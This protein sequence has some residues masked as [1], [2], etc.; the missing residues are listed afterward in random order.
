MSTTGAKTG[1]HSWLRSHDLGRGHTSVSPEIDRLSRHQRLAHSAER[2]VQGTGCGT[3]K[4][5]EL[6]EVK[7]PPGVP[8]AF[9]TTRGAVCDVAV[10]VGERS[11]Y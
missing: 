7:I 9:F 4:H 1:S 11:R 3:K 2:T 6:G 8:Q 10:G 5:N